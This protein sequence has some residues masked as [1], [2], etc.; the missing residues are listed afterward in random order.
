MFDASPAWQ[1]IWF[2]ALSVPTLIAV[3]MF[4]KTAGPEGTAPFA[5]DRFTGAVGIVEETVQARGAAGMIRVNGEEWSAKTQEP[6]PIPAGTEVDVLR[7][8]GAHL[9]V[10]THRPGTPVGLEGGSE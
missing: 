5:S 4:V 7:M 3:K 10:R 2:I 1:W 6:A 8:D 9:I